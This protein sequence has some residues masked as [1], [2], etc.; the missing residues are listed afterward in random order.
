MLIFPYNFKMGIKCLTTWLSIKFNFLAPMDLR[1]IR[2]EASAVNPK[3]SNP[4]WNCH[5]RDVY[6]SH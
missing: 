1:N 6:G 2:H 4:T 3:M 5:K